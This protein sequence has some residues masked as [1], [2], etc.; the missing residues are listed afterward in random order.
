MVICLW[1]QATIEIE[2][3][4]DVGGLDACGC[5]APKVQNLN[6]ALVADKDGIS[7]KA[8]PADARGMEVIDGAL[9]KR[10]FDVGQ[11]G[12]GTDALHERSH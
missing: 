6:G 11:V 1:L 7:A 2:A 3:T 9:A 8:N 10:A 5:R 4:G 12:L